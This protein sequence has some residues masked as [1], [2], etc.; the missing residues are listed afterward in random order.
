MD[1]ASIY[2]MLKSL[3]VVWFFLV[4]A[5]IVAWALWP[6]RRKR[7]EKHGEIPLRKDDT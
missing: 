5:G 2:P 7:L 1:W 4:F 6:S 3:W